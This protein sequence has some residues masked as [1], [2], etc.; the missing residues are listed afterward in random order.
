MIYYGSKGKKTN[1][2]LKDRIFLR[3]GGTVAFLV[4]NELRPHGPRYWALRDMFERFGQ[5]AVVRG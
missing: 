3:N 1:Q 5:L 2:S 4:F